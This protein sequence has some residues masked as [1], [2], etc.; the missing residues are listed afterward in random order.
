MGDARVP[1]GA[2][3]VRQPVALLGQLREPEARAQQ[4]QV[5]G[6][7]LAGDL[8]QLALLVRRAPL[9]ADP[10][11]RDVRAVPVWPDEVGVEGD[12]V[13]FRE[14]PR[15]ALLEPRVGARPGGQQPGLDPLPAPLDVLR[16]ED[17]PEVVLRHPRPHR[18]P[19][20]PDA[21]L[22][23]G[24]GAAHGVDLVRVLDLAGVFGDPLPIPDVDPEPVEGPHPG[25]LHLVDGEA[26]VA[27]AVRAQQVVHLCGEAPRQLFRALAGQ[28]VEEGGD[29]PDL[30]DERQVV[31]EVHRLAVLEQDHGAVGRDEAG[32]G[33]VVGNPHLHVGGVRRVADVEG[34]ED[35][36]PRAVVAAE[37]AAQP[38]QPVLPERGQVRDPHPGPL[39]L[40]EGER[41][42]A[43]LDAVGV[44]RGA[45][46][47]PPRF[48]RGRAPPAARAPPAG[49]DLRRRNGVAVTHRPATSKGARKRPGASPPCPAQ[50]HSLS[51]PRPESGHRGCRAG[52]TK[53]RFP[54]DGAGVRVA[55]AFLSDGTANEER[56]CL[57]RRS[58]WCLRLRSCSRPSTS[59]IR[60]GRRARATASGGAYPSPGALRTCRFRVSS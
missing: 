14:D 35:E 16:V 41:G 15:T 23:G 30:V 45:V 52:M 40:P 47:P 51:A 31:G 48:A 1:P 24:H 56:S 60:V 42:R 18:S 43:D 26:P 6:D 12:Q 32:A 19:H 7:V 53:G 34:V 55:M 8:V 10:G 38:L 5:G 22:A 9:A 28:E 2:V 33:G 29:G 11:A 49:M 44:V 4:L 46:R 37:L 20:L 39:P 54:S 13:P 57:P 50:G 59:V 17:R 3:A 27:P 36:Q 21:R 25:D 58:H